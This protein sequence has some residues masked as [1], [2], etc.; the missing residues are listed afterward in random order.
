MLATIELNFDDDGY[1]MNDMH[2]SLL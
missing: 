1:C 2:N